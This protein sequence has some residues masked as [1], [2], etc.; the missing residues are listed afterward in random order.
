MHALTVIVIVI[1]RFL[2]RYS[3]AKRTRAP[4]YSRALRRI[5]GGFSKGVKGSS[6]PISR[7]P[8][9]DRVA[10]KVGVVQVEKVNDQM[11]QGRSVCRDEILILSRRPGGDG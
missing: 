4:S 9:G 8:G 5:K 2:K 11:G 10:V 3:K 6:G 1:S 7:I